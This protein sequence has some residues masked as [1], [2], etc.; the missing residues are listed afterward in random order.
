MIWPNFASGKLGHLRMADMLCRNFTGGDPS[1]FH[2]LY[3]DAV[4]TDL[5]FLAS[6]LRAAA[7]RGELDRIE[8]DPDLLAQRAQLEQ[9]QARM[10]DDMARFLQQKLRELAGKRVFVMGSY[11]LLYELATEGLARGVEAVFA[12]GSVVASGGGAKGIVLPPDWQEPVLKFFGVDHLRMGYGMSEISAMHMMC[13]SGR[14]HVQPWVIP[15][16][17]H[18]DTN[19]PYPAK[20]CRSGG[21]RSTT[22]PTTPTGAGS[23]R[24]TRSSSATSPARAAGRPST[25]H[26]RS[27]ATAR[28]RATIASPARRRSSSSTRPSTS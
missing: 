16:V 5:M 28:S 19:E 14:Y 11:N 26:R 20:A 21:P 27:S 17:L 13:E 10:P 23:C 3:G 24:A 2:A 1:R 7:S 4:S 15:Y 25:S 8:I 9:M 12:P 18:P 22:R 6:K